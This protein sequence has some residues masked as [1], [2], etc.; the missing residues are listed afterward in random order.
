MPTG[1]E[2][3]RRQFIAYPAIALLAF[4]V[5]SNTFD[6]PFVF[7]DGMYITGNPEIRSISSLWPLTTRS[8][9]YLSF[10]LN[11]R[12]GGLDVFGYHIVNTAIHAANASL[13]FFMVSRTFATPWM[14]GA[15]QS[16]G[17]AFGAAVLSSVIFAVHPVQTQAVTYITQRFASLATLFYLLS[18][19]SYIAWRARE[20]GGALI[21]ALS[22]V[23]A[24]CAQFTKEM[25][26]TLPLV[27]LLYET[28]FYEGPYK[29][30]LFRVIPFLFVMLIIPLMVLS[31]PSAEGAGI[32]S[33]IM[34]KQLL[35]MT[36]L[37]PYSYFVTELRVIVTY[38]R[39][40]V[41][42]I[43]QNIDYSYPL[44]NSI[45][46]P[47][48][49]ASFL[50]L[51]STLA[52]AVCLFVISR[53]R[54]DAFLS[55]V[56]AGVFWFFMTISIESSFI[57]IQ[58]VI[59]EHRLYLPSI[60]AFAAFGAL[61]FFLKERFLKRGSNAA[62]GVVLAVL[63][64][65]PLGGAAYL[66]NEVWRDDAALWKDAIAKSPL[67]ARPHASLGDVYLRRGL[68][69]DAITEFEKAVSFSPDAVALYNLGS[70]YFAGGLYGDAAMAY[71]ASL[72]RRP[73]KAGTRHNL[74]I[75]YLKLGMDEDAL[76]EFEEA[77]RLEPGRSDSHYELARIYER[78]GWVDDAAR[79][80][81]AAKMLRSAE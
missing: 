72:G 49:L 14:K 18:L 19:A 43:G 46:A 32:S 23:S 53:K 63:L 1:R 78:K 24:V 79:E 13:V 33:N 75:A 27:I 69:N 70:A 2:M 80:F 37:S 22:L 20:K 8:L 57:P 71:R 54:R 21:Y 55:L 73:D 51:F 48:V 6:A 38:L 65:I 17:G 50:F 42:P 12:F 74:G 52:G 26:F 9:A 25:A 4:I 62:F 5:Y 77:A 45:F 64:A 61:I 59:F 56:S 34:R 40:L 47:G 10:A 11:F 60:G 29:K 7:D 39:L 41:L 76:R 35:E 67:K 28:A 66:R 36:G 44:Y 31:A 68:V 30:R 3:D 16:A 58:D 81:E 15:L